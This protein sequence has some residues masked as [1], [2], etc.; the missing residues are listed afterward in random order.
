[1]SLPLSFIIIVYCV[2]CI[3]AQG[4]MDVNRPFHYAA[5]LKS[6]SVKLFTLYKPVQKLD[7]FVTVFH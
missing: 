1:M 4:H 6:V 7:T 3:G 2:Y 5:A